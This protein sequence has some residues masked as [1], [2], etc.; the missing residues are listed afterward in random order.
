MAKIVDKEAKRL[1]LM[2]AALE[3]FLEKGYKSV[4]TRE[5]AAKAG[6]SKGFLYDYFKNKEDLFH[7]TIKENITKNLLYKNLTQE[8]DVSPEEKFAKL[9]DVASC[10]SDTRKQRFYMIFDFLVNCPDDKTK[11]DVMGDLYEISRRH[12]MEI[13][14]EAFPGAF[15]DKNSARLHANTIVAFLDGILFQ[16]FVDP[17]KA[18]L[19]ETIDLFWSFLTDFLKNQSE[20][21]NLSAE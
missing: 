13:L 19:Q 8:E 12:M 1:Q 6:V 21:A 18:R 4:T 3:L 10:N 5:I 7:Q 15:D 16:H 14:T 9:K 2:E 17:D 11:N 20:A